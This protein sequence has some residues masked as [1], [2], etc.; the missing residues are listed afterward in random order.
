MTFLVDANVVIYSAIESPYRAPCLEL[1]SAIARGRAPGRLSTAILE[2][3]WHVE[4][5]G[6]AGDLTGLTSRA[7]TAFTPLLP[8]TDT[9]F[10]M[11]LS[12]DAPALGTNDRLHAAVCH[13]HSIDS[14]VTAD[15]DFDGVSG[16]R[17][18]DPLDE[19]ALRTLLG[20]S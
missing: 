12:L 6:R 15:A 5:S 20:V 9:T 3:V 16:L 7:Y 17:R 4:R 13:E 11:A 14:I 10:S 2:E 8:V 18:V 19:P 1:L